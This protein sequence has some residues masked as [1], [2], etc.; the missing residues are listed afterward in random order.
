MLGRDLLLQLVERSGSEGI[1]ADETRAESFSLVMHCQLPTK[2]SHVSSLFGRSRNGEGSRTFVHVVVLPAPWIPTAMSTFDFPLTGLYGSVPG[3]TSA[4]SSSNTACGSV[5]ISELS[6]R[7]GEGHTFCTICF[8][9]D[10]L[11]PWFDPSA[12][13]RLFLTCFQHQPRDPTTV[14]ERLTLAR[15]F[16]LND[17]TSF[18]FTSASSN[19]D[20]SSL[21]TASIAYTQVVNPGETRGE[22]GNVP[23]RLRRRPSRAAPGRSLV[24][25][26][27]L[28]EP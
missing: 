1:R 10:S 7:R 17:D 23:C 9:F 28:R 5:V 16:V 3:S 25:A 8:L 21:M 12:S 19:A 4:T 2:K 26:L 15:I 14:A 6:S 20:T 18:T 13:S 22:A 24:F 11:R 27:N